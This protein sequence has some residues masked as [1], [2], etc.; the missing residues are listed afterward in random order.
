MA[1]IYIAGIAIFNS[2]KLLNRHGKY[3]RIFSDI[4]TSRSQYF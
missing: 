4:R 2:L 1:V 3:K